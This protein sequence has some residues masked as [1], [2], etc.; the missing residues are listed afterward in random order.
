MLKVTPT[1]LARYGVV[2]ASVVVALLIRLLLSATFGVEG[3]FVIFLLAVMVSAWYGGFWSGMV[4]T[5]LSAVLGNYFFISPYAL[6]VGNTAAQVGIVLFLIEGYVISALNEAMRASWRGAEQSSLEAEQHRHM[7]RQSEE[8]YRLLVENV[9]D[10]AI[11]VLDKAGRIVDCGPGVEH[12]FG[13]SNEELANKSFAVIFVPEDVDE[14]VPAQ[15]L[16]RA[17]A[18]GREED[19]RWHLRKDGTRFQASGVVTAIRDETG[20]LRGFTKVARDITERMEM[21]AELRRNEV[22]SA[23]GRLVSSVAHEVRNPLFA[24]SS[25]LDAFE[26]RFSER[27]EYERYTTRLRAELGRLNQLMEELLTYGRPYRQEFREGSIADVLQEAASACRPLAD[28]SQVTIECDIPEGLMTVMHDP[29]RLPLVFINLMKNAILYSPPGKAVVVRAVEEVGTGDT[30]R[31]E[32][33]VEDSG[34]GFKEEDLTM[35]FE[36]FFT[37]RQGGTG[38]G[39][40]IAQRIVEEHCGQIR[41]RN[42]PGGGA[43]IH[44]RIPVAAD[45]ASCEEPADVKE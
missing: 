12:I 6:A 37:R 4:A 13:Y 45:P 8:R 9:R 22:L 38:L 41:A 2:F 18:E 11:F 26:A 3:P 42:R 32:C 36:P 19:E 15:V 5:F 40:A 14:G 24:I 44:V 21:E 10:Y 16:K 34:P 39:L 20:A 43:A 1:T 35:I 7:L 25:A 17:A 30:K 29:K 31:V 33:I 27:T 23:M 28:A